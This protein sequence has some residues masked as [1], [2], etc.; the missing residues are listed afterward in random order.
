MNACTAGWTAKLGFRA[1]TA[2]RPLLLV[3]LITAWLLSAPQAQAQRPATIRLLPK[4]TL[5]LVTVPDAQL[6]AERFMATNFGRMLQEPQIKPLVTQLYNDVRNELGGV[7]ERL[8]VTIDEL[9]ALPQGEMS[10]ALVPSPEGNLAVVALIE[11]S[12][13]QR[14]AQKLLEQV[15]KELKA[16]GVEVAEE[17]IGETRITYYQMRRQQF[18]YFER[19][20]AVVLS[21]NWGAL[22]NILTAWDQGIEEPLA[23]NRSFAAVHEKCR[24]LRD[25]P[26]QF[27]WYAD[28][29]ALTKAL[30][31]REGSNAL[32]L[33]LLQPLGLEGIRAVGG[34]LTMV[35]QRFDIIAQA[36]VLLAEPREG[37]LNLPTF[38]SGNTRPEAWIPDDAAAYTTIN[39]DFGLTYDKV[40]RLVDRFTAEGATAA[41]V[42]QT[43]DRLGLHFEDDVLSHLD[44]RLTIAAW[45]QKPSTTFTSV[46]QLFGLRLKDPTRF[47]PIL[48]KVIERFPDRFEK[49]NYAGVIY[50]RINTNRRPRRLLEDENAQPPSPAI[51][52]IGSHLVF[53]DRHVAI[54]RAI[55]ASRD[56]SRTLAKAIDFK[57]I[58]S[59]AERMVGEGQ[60]CLLSFNRPEENFRMMYE[61]AT[62]QQNREALGRRG[63]T[64]RGLRIVHRALEANPL[65]PFE[66]LR[67]YLAPGGAVLIDDASGLHYISFTLRRDSGD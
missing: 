51:A 28:P 18:A 23:D 34:S 40:R 32:V 36:H 54:E 35:T 61:I 3:T 17:T 15:S 41:Q 49:D 20:G 42:Q 1:G 29:I 31:P 47:R 11:V 27:F 52:I 4:D 43:F 55:A 33:A 64:N 66:T 56:P 53:S 22:A 37:I 25:E 9:L 57:L 26:P 7:E 16:R 38:I 14:T 58:V 19:D 62:N 10:V 50:Y 48:E 39:F 12:D 60:M 13:Q 30:I 59:Q 45:I 65:P 21:S 63:E 67:K 8:G 24:G 6:F 2:H 46:A 5:A 44:N